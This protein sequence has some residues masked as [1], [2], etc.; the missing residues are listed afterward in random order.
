M[1]MVL[2]MMILELNYVIITTIDRFIIERS[3]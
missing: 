3:Y 1:M 2:V